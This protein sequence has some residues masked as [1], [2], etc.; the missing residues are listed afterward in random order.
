ME[1]MKIAA[2]SLFLLKMSSHSSRFE[3]DSKMGGVESFGSER[4][5][6]RAFSGSGIVQMA[7]MT[8]G[9]DGEVILNHPRV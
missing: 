5:S 2:R 7:E 6:K 8:V 9:G 4:E 3:L 1:K